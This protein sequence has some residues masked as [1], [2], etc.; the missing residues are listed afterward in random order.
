MHQVSIVRLYVLRAMYLL[1]LV[2]LATQ[3]WPLILNPPDNL[4]H[5]RGVVWSVLT[6]I[7]L[8][9]ALGIRYPL[10]MLPLLFFEFAWKVIWVVAIGF[11]L[12]SSNSFDAAH[13]ETWFNCWLGVVLVPLVLPWRYVIETY[14]KAP[15]D[16]WRRAA[17]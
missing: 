11:P 6:A 17:A 7:S 5:F 15:A 8:V 1:M 2:G 3:I 12:W 13:Q 16:R 4:E 10:A 14:V 9:A